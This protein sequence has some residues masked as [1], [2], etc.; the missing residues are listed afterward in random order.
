MIPPKGP[1][2]S[3]RASTLD[4][5][6]DPPPGDPDSTDSGIT[7]REAFSPARPIGCKK[8]KRARKQ[9]FKSEEDVEDRKEA[10]KRS[11]ELL[12]RRVEDMEKGNTLTEQI[13]EGE[14]KDKESSVKKNLAE[15]KEIEL[16]S[17]LR[18]IEILNAS[19]NKCP[20]ELSKETLRAMKLK[21]RQKYL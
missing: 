5:T 8:A 19:E 4:F 16:N 18:E 21:I 9:S 2:P 12:I 20:D 1:K 7:P 17:Q 6:S 3:R 11:L 14:R 15:V 13:L 10:T